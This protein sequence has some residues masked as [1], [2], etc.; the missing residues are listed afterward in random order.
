MTMHEMSLKLRKVLPNIDV[1]GELRDA[2]GVLVRVPMH[3]VDAASI[4]EIEQNLVRAGASA[5]HWAPESRG[6]TLKVRVY[7]ERS[8][9]M[10]VLGLL[11]IV[12][13]GSLLQYDVLHYFAKAS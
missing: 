13:V 4:D 10:T 6:N 2:P 7:F 1:L 9:T 3:D 12:V 11:A 8:W 5:W